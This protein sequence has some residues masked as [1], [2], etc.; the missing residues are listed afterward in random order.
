MHIIISF[1]LIVS[2][3]F[4]PD[5]GFEKTISDSFR[6]KN[7]RQLAKYF[8]P[9]LNVSID[10]K[11]QVYSNVQAEAVLRKKL[12]NLQIS[13]FSYVHKSQ[14]SQSK[15]YIGIIKTNKENYSVNINLSKQSS[16]WKITELQVNQK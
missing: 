1:Y 16:G 10:G 6:S 15:Y 3:L 14:A 9:R 11:S 7:T 2:T 12:S 13:N 8:A 4:Q 5:T